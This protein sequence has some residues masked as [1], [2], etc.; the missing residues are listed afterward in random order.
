MSAGQYP[1]TMVDLTTNDDGIRAGAPRLLVI[2]TFEGQD[3]PV[4]RMTD[5]QSGRLPH[6]RTG[7]YHVVIDAAGRSGRENDNEYIPWAAGWTGNR[8]GLHVSLAGRAAFTREQWLARGPQLV[9]LARWLAH[10]SKANGIPLTVVPV[11]GI[12][13][14]GKGVCSHA[15]IAR[16]FPKETDHTDPGPGFPWD[17]VLALARNGGMSPNPSHT[18][19]ERTLTMDPQQ[20]HQLDD[21]TEQ[22]TGSP[23][24]AHFPGWPQLD[25]RTIVDALAVIGQK[26]GIPG[27]YDPRKL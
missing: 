1:T 8:I 7:S 17:H 15:D 13:G 2:H 5:Y 12:R 22:L 20:A 3:L 14:T 19:P 23:D 25:D 24:P 10:E 11:D 9:E 18:T 16:A 27:F 21:V 4:E 26:M 6:Q